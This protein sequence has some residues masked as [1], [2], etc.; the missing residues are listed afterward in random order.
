M[1]FILY[2]VDD[3]Q[4]IRRSCLP[5]SAPAAHLLLL[6]QKEADGVDPPHPLQYCS[7]HPETTV[8]DFAGWSRLITKNLDSI[9][10]I[11]NRNPGA[12]H[13]LPPGFL[14][15]K[16]NSDAKG[17]ADEYIHTGGWAIIHT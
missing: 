5:E 10:V 11:Q 16:L 8:E 14:K 13:V 1:I 9:L 7:I 3:R 6:R 12:L 17:I 15:L 2:W 4:Q